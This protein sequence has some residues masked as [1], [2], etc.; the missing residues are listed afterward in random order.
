VVALLQHSRP[1]IAALLEERDALL[2][3]ARGA[4][5]DA[6]LQEEAVAALQRVQSQYQVTSATFLLAFSSLISAPQLC[7]WLVASYPWAPSLASLHATV[8]ARAEAAAAAAAAADAA[9]PRRGRPR[10]AGPRPALPASGGSGVAAAAA[11]AA[12]TA[13]ALASGAG[14][15]GGLPADERDH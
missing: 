13:A 4:P 15:P 6:D 1:R 3:A 7:S 5:G 12:A 11:A 9:R 8:L 14:P 10:K 2:A